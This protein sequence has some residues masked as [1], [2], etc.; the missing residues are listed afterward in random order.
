MLIFHF[1]FYF[2]RQDFQTYTSAENIVF[3][4]LVSLT[5]WNRVIVY[6]SILKILIFPAGKGLTSWRHSA[7]DGQRTLYSHQRG[8]DLTLLPLSSIY[9]QI[10]VTSISSSQVL[11]I[12]SMRCPSLML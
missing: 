11:F 10:C 12:P 3:T 4:F 2:A 6:V 8:P 9:F 1:V 5:Q 7:L